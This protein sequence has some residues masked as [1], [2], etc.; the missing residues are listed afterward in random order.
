MKI[1]FSLIIVF[2]VAVS[3]KTMELKHIVTADKPTKWETK[4]FQEINDYV[5]K[6]TGKKLKIYKYSSPNRPEHNCLFIGSA[7]LKGGFVNRDDVKKLKIDGYLIAGKNNNAAVYGP[8]SAGV[9]FGA[10]GLMDEAGIKIYGEDCEVLPKQFKLPS[11]FKKIVNP[12]FEMR[13]MEAGFWRWNKYYRRTNVTRLGF[14]AQFEKE[15]LGELFS[16][17]WVDPKVSFSGNGH[18]TKFMI[19]KYKYWKSNPEYFAHDKNGK[20]IIP[21]RLPHICT[22]NKEVKKICEK[23]VLDWVAEFP[24]TSF[25]FVGQ[26]DLWG[27]CECPA[28]RALDPFPGKKKGRRYAYLADRLACF[29]NPIAAAVKKH[30]SNK[31]ILFIAYREASEPLVREKLEDNVRV[32][33]CSSPS[34]G[35]PCKS[36]DLQCP[37]NKR[38][39]ESFKGWLKA[40]PGKVYIWNYCMNFKNRYS[41]F[42]PLD[43][44]V[45]KLRYYHRNRI[46]GM[47]YNGA[48]RLFIQLF[49]YV[50]GKLLWNPDLD[51]RKLEN[52]FMQAFYGPA[53]PAMK[54]LLDLMR[55]RVNDKRDPVHQGEY[56]LFDPLIEPEYLKQAN[57]IFKR[58]E[59]A[60]AGKPEL[61]KRVKYEKLSAVLMPELDGGFSK[62]AVHKLDVLRQ[63]AEVVNQ[64]KL[65]KIKGGRTRMDALI[66]KKF[67]F[68]IKY[69][70]RAWTDAPLIK[71]LLHCKNKKQLKAFAQKVKSLI[72]RPQAFKQIS[73][74]RIKLLLA[75]FNIHGCGFGPAFYSHQCAKRIAIGALGGDLLETNFK[76]DRIADGKLKLTALDHDKARAVAIKILLND[77]EIFK[78]DNKASKTKW[79]DLYFSV[80]ADCLK[81]DNILKIKNLEKNEAMR[82]WIMLADAEFIFNER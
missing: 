64:W 18:T 35:A 12:A 4:A 33:L 79:T 29:V 73:P 72:K 68:N 3:G 21:H 81:N 9:L 75:G 78:G 47:F 36:H 13:Y 5:E 71:E 11:S 42:F 63:I 51:V 6:I 77:H 38:F 2:A 50:Q 28:C 52:E 25:F 82:N 61:L 58:A 10:Y 30:D 67:G 27:W 26:E 46:K 49:C 31:R 8:Y 74:N 80:P 44:M 53:A 43:S 60:V 24:L 55:S 39:F 54:E 32:V 16:G 65:T 57:E 19:P 76:V 66:Y 69:S 20:L 56:S 1:F 70:G 62:D 7:A 48:P 41:P 15:K 23:T 14:S 59:A 17:Q 34:A 37:R 40:A 22:T 45:K